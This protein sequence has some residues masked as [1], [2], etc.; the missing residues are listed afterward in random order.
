MTKLEISTFSGDKNKDGINPMEWLTWVKEN[1]LNPIMV[2]FI[3]GLNLGSGGWEL[4]KIIDQDVNKLK[5]PCKKD[6]VMTK[7]FKIWK[8]IKMN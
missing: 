4:M 7:K 5:N 1:G 6:E 8:Q 2:S 3:L